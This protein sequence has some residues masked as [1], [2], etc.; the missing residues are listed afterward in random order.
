MLTI[1]DGG[2]IHKKPIELKKI[3]IKEI[4]LGSRLLY[5]DG[6]KADITK[7]LSNIL[8]KRELA[9]IINN[10]SHYRGAKIAYYYT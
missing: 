4:N 2:N 1:D 9:Y 8:D 7:Q 5:N 10:E 3:L 6:G